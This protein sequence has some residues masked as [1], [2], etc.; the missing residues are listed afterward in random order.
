MKLP[1]LLQIILLITLLAGTASASHNFDNTEK[2]FN[3]N[4]ETHTL[5]SIESVI[6]NP[7][8]VRNVGS[9][10]YVNCSIDMDSSSKLTIENANVIWGSADYAIKG[11][12]LSTNNADIKVYNYNLKRYIT[13]NDADSSGVYI[14]PN[15]A[16][17]N[18]T[19]FQGIDYLEANVYPTGQKINNVS[20]YDCT[21]RSGV[22][23]INPCTDVTVSGLV[24]R[25]VPACGLRI[26]STKGFLLENADI[27]HC[28]TYKDYTDGGGPTGAEGIEIYGDDSAPNYDT[29]LRNVYVN[30]TS[31]SAINTEGNGAVY[32]I[33]GY[34]VTVDWA[35]HNAFD[36]H[37]GSG[38]YLD[39][40]KC[41]NGME[42]SALYVSSY[43]T[44]IKNAVLTNN[45]GCCLEVDSPNTDN[46]GTWAVNNTF[47]NI[48]TYGDSRGIQVLSAKGN[49]FVNVKSYN[50]SDS[51]GCYLGSYDDFGYTFK[52]SDISIVDFSGNN[53]MWLEDGTGH[54]LVNSKWGSM[55]LQRAQYQT[56]YYPNLIVK[57]ESGN[58]V[59]GASIKCSNS[60]NG[61]GIAQ[62]TFTT[63]SN[64]KLEGSRSNWLAIPSQ[65]SITASKDGISK[66]I[67][68]TPS[69]SWYSASHASLQG[70]LQT[71]VL[72]VQ[73][74]NN[75]TEPPITPP[76][77]NTTEPPIIPVNNTTVEPTEPDIPTAAFSASIRSGVMPI[78][79]TFTDLSTGPI[80]SR[81]WTFGDGY[82]STMKNPTHTYKKVGNFN[83]S[84]TVKNAAGNDK[85]TKNAYIVV[86][87]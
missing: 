46:G 62:T 56:Y 59:S 9:T 51:Y 80:I 2:V 76:E 47:E 57:D 48:T 3:V 53:I 33:K 74:E 66:S 29:T 70:P 64:G 17:V 4:S 19:R 24:I 60:V 10:Y 32:R 55:I 85:L 8:I 37:G 65:T 67:T 50:P 25:N 7:S 13:R 36:L 43:D 42:Q 78:K 26:L 69:E 15:R 45:R 6:N 61:Y 79:V 75:T 22:F 52:P 72:G 82:S 5:A 86:R 73:G 11:G 31:Y 84:L 38:H 63:G 39:G 54:K 27:Q 28:G 34:N 41:S 14:A 83:V 49:R 58:P 23:V 35:A 12:T 77:N 16:L 44:I 71:I 87:G 30:D 40:L 81:K 20:F 1:H 18:N 68:A 21:S